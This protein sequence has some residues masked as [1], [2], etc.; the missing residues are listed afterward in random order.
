MDEVLE[1]WNAAV[2]LR[3]AAVRRCSTVGQVRDAVRRARAD[4]MALSVLGGGH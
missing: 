1:I 2:P 4:G 3:P